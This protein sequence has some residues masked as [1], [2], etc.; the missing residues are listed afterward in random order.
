VLAGNVVIAPFGTV[1]FKDAYVGLISNL[2]FE[3]KRRNNPF[4][5]PTQIEVHIELTFHRV[6]FSGDILRRW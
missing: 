2:H 5:W 4:L 6:C 1:Q 3:R